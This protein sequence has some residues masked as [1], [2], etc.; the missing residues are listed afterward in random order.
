MD[1]DELELG[2]LARILLMLAD[3]GIIS[4]ACTMRENDNLNWNLLLKPV[5]NTLQMAS[6]RPYM[7]KKNFLSCAKFISLLI[8]ESNGCKESEKDLHTCSILQCLQNCSEMFEFMFQMLFIISDKSSF[9]SQ[10]NI[11]FEAFCSFAS[12]PTLKSLFSNMVP[13][14][15]KK[16]DDL[17]EDTIH[18]RYLLFPLWKMLNS[19]VSNATSVGSEDF[20]KSNMQK[21]KVI[22]KVTNASL[23]WECLTLPICLDRIEKEQWLQYSYNAVCYFWE[24]SSFDSSEISVVALPLADEAKK[25]F[26]KGPKLAV[27]CVI[28][29]LK[30]IVPELGLQDVNAMSELLDAGWSACLELHGNEAF[31]PALNAFIEVLFQT[32]MLKDIFFDILYKYIDKL[33]ELSENTIG[34]FYN[35]MKQFCDSFTVEN[36][37]N[38]KFYCIP[39][40]VYALTFG[41]I[42]Q[43][44]HKIMEETLIYLIERDIDFANSLIFCENNKPSRYVRVVITNY[45]LNNLFI[46]KEE[47]S[48]KIATQLLKV[49][50]DD[51]GK[52]SSHFANSFSHRIRNRAWQSILLIQQCIKN[53]NLNEQLLLKTLDT[54]GTENQ[55]PSIR[56]LQ[57]WLIFNIVKSHTNLLNKYVSLF[58]QSLEKRPSYVISVLSVTNLLIL[59]KVL[60]KES[61]I[62]KC[63]KIITVLCMA[64][65]FTVRL[66]AQMALTN[67]FSLCQEEKLES[68][69]QKH[70]FVLQ[71]VEM[72]KSLAGQGNFFKNVTKL[73]N[74]F[75]FSVFKPDTHFTLETIFYE[76]PRITNLTPDEWIKP[77]LFEDN[78]K[79]PVYNLNND[80]KDS[81]PTSWAFKSNTETP[82]IEETS[83]DYNFQKKIIPIKDMLN[84]H[85]GLNLVDDSDK[86]ACKD[87]LIVVA[88]LIDRIPNLGGLCRTCEVFAVS[89]FVIGS[90]RYVD[91]KQFQTLAVSADKWVPIKEVKPHQLKDY[92]ILMK[93][94]GYALIGAEQT[95]DSCTLSDYCF[96]KKSVL[97]LGHE[98]EGL[99]VDLI[100]LLDVCVEIPQQ[101]V[102]RS[103][104]VHVSG[105]ILIWEYA[106]QH[107]KS[108]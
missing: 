20:H 6:K 93:E 15:I 10:N 9:I 45:L 68:V 12:E 33:K 62:L 43:K 5:F 58:E 27:P 90:M 69:I 98:K 107:I 48:Y 19:I 105:A 76:L 55:Q 31:R 89:E 99:S 18:R 70:Q 44:A 61:D 13:I 86:K 57:E 34:L 21:L 92:L 56:Y 64:Q 77:S 79:I 74:D 73:S 66:Y 42:H 87:G 80:L 24:V 46:I 59:H 100:Q 53:D 96:P 102:V 82:A 95:E 3:I 63:F 54:L 37:I 51:N 22:S 40:F 14:L 11:I 39:V 101:G 17:L 23:L 52:Q 71:L 84:D 7:N 16:V 67:L 28:R 94:K 104:N 25:M 72:Q 30:F 38:S 26:D 4:P 29:S 106:R 32:K 36:L 108:S 75:Y 88:S 78:L 103:L 41:P 35:F 81:V 97:L 47:F 50:I 85:E 2:K 60:V 49:D 83:M 65:N 1:I 91:D 8:K